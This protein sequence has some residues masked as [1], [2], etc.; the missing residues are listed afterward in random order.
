MFISCRSPLVEFLGSLMYSII[1]SANNDTLTSSFPICIH[2]ISFYCLIALEPQVLYWI[3][4]ER[5]DSLVL[6]LILVELPWV[7]SPFHLMLAVGLL[8][9]AFIMFRYSPY[10]PTLS[11]TSLMK[12][13][14]V[15]SK[16]VSASNE[17][18]IT[19]KISHS[20]YSVLSK[21][22]GVHISVDKEIY[23]VGFLPLCFGFCLLSF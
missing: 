6:F 10:L 8:Q 18:I 2:S 15:L 1:S 11:R 3:A 17:M 4:M 12:G 16:A 22:L 13:C 20:A 7:S 23:Q 5:V 21:M 9:I 19:S 14:W